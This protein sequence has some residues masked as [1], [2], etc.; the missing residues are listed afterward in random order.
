MDYGTY[1]IKKYKKIKLMGLNLYL[2]RSGSGLFWKE[3]GFCCHLGKRIVETFPTNFSIWFLS[4][5]NS[6]QLQR[7]DDEAEQAVDTFLN[8]YVLNSSYHVQI[9]CSYLSIQSYILVCQNIRTG[10]RYFLYL[11]NNYGLVN[12]NSSYG[13][14][15][16]SAQIFQFSFSQFA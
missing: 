2:V 12:L 8:N 6:R 16:Q 11:L 7:P 14:Q 13:L 9:L 3:G 10:R 15:L 4:P 5:V 1:F